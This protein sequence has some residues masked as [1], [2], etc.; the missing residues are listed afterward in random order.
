M[1][2]NG[3]EDVA[4]DKARLPRAPHRPARVQWMRAVLTMIPF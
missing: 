3:H 1:T 2:A 4:A